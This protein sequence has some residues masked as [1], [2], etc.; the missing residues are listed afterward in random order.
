MHTDQWKTIQM[1]CLWEF[2][3]SIRTLKTTHENTYQG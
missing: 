3:Q 2:F 1:Q